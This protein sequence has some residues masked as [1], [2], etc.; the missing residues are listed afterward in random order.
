MVERLRVE[1]FRER[2]LGERERHRAQCLQLS[3]ESRGWLSALLSDAMPRKIY[4]ERRGHFEN[5]GWEK[6]L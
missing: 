4:S 1:I 3:F 5:A 2:K 6:S